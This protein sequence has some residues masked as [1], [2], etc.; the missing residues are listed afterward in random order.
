MKARVLVVE[1]Q[2]LVRLGLAAILSG[3]P[4][5]LVCGEGGTA[6]QA[7]AQYRALRPDVMLLDLHLPDESGAIATAR[8]RDEFTDA[9]IIGLASANPAA[10]VRAV[11]AA[12]ARAC[13]LRTID[14]GELRG[15]VH[16]VLRGERSV[17]GAI[18]EW[19]IGPGEIT[20]REREILAHLVRGRTNREIAAAL[21]ISVGT[22]KTHLAKT[23]QKLQVVGRT[24]AA[25]V[26]IER[27]IVRRS[28]A[29]RTERGA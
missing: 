9:R 18:A 16:A 23:C 28:A 6:A 24:A 27:G 29:L 11:L 10:E 3:D 1:S 22:V 26:A 8:I 21:Q 4:A 14:E 15:V 17:P 13:V 19:S 5:L 20:E 12:G 25:A 7:V 2:P